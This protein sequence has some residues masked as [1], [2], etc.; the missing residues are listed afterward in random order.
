[1]GLWVVRIVFIIVCPLRDE[2][3]IGGIVQERLASGSGGGGGA[4]LPGSWLGPLLG[5]GFQAVL[6]NRTAVVHLF[7]LLHTGAVVRLQGDLE[8]ED[9]AA[10]LAHA[11]LV[12]PEIKYLTRLGNC[13]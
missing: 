11:G 6:E 3:R 9:A 1:M 5:T 13:I 8:L 7:P 4:G 2:R 10:L 12:G